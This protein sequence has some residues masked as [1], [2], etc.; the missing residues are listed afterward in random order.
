V[1]V[2]EGVVVVVAPVAGLVLVAEPAGAV[3]AVVV[4]LSVAGG[5]AAAVLSVAVVVSAA[6]LLQPASDRLVAASRAVAI[7]AVRGMASCI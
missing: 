5:V 7:T 2:P 3:V 4:V 1:V 6:F